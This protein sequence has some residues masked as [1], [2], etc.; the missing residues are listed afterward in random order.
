M[1]RDGTVMMS[2]NAKDA[3][4]SSFYE[5]I[6]CDD[7]KGNP[8]LTATSADNLVFI[9][10]PPQKPLIDSLRETGVG[11][12]TPISLAEAERQHAFSRF[13]V[14]FGSTPQGPEAVLVD[15]DNEKQ[16]EALKIIKP[17]MVILRPAAN[18]LHLC[19]KFFNWLQE[20]S[21]DIPVI[22]NFRYDCSQEDLVIRAAAEYGSLFCDGLGDGIWLEGPYEPAFLRTLSFNILQSARMRIVKTDFISC[23]SCGRTLF[24][25]QDVTK[26]IRSRTAH[27]PGV[28]IA[29]MGCIVNGPGEMADAD[30][31]YVGSKPGKIDLYVGK[32]CVERDIAFED[33]DDRLIALIKTHNRWVDEEADE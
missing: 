7:T 22:L 12:V 10:S 17:A 1:H 33:A 3:M 23:P 30:F 27:L 16:W 19:R 2:V 21:L 11:T 14:K 28:K 20:N 13:A 26:R 15:E 8:K 32:E 6:G 29:I 9:D 5:M 25:L 4:H 31:G 24:N 18:R